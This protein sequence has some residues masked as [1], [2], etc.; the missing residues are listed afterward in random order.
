MDETHEIEDSV[1]KLFK[2]ATGNKYPANDSEEKPLFTKEDLDILKELAAST[3]DP[4]G[5]HYQMLR[6]MLHTEQNYRGAYRR[7]GI[8][9][10]LEKTLKQHAFVNE[11]QALQFKLN[12]TDQIYTYVDISS[13]DDLTDVAEEV[14]NENIQ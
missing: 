5:I 8:F 4:D 10:S 11:E 3:D 12:H 2:L 1:P 7:H 6:E 9:E 13:D 14:I